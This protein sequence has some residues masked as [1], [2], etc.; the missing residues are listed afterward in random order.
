MTFILTLL[1]LCFVVVTL[2]IVFLIMKLI[3]NLGRLVVNLITL[4]AM[5]LRT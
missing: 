1:L 2:Q 5:A 4:A 3:W